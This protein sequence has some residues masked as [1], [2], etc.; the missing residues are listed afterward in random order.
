MRHL[1]AA[2]F[3]LG[4]SAQLNAQW[5]HEWTSTAVDLNAVA[6]WVAFELNGDELTYRFY[7]IDASQIVIMSGTESSTPQYSYSFSAAEQL[8]GNYIYSLG[9]DLTGDGIVEF[10]VLGYAGTEGNYRQSFR[11]LDITNGATVFARDDASI[12]Y[13]EPTVWDPDDDGLLECTFAFWD[14]PTGSTYAYEV[15]NTGIVAGLSQAA[16]VPLNVELGQNFPNPFNP[17]TTIE[18]SLQRRGRV[19]IEI[20]N[21]LGQKVHTLTDHDYATGRH[22]V[23]WRGINDSGVR[24]AS[25]SYFYSLK[26]GDQTLQAKRMILLR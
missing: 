3:I 18:F 2:I 20:F 17:E 4:G 7:S 25:G 5:Q 8:A 9:Q 13:G 11:V 10:Y 21:S 23:L 24:L 26:I 22:A 14:Y 1:L 12:S 6:G 19:Q 16:G 15:Y